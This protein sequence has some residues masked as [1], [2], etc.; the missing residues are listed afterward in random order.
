[1]NYCINIGFLIIGNSVL[2]L[3][4]GKDRKR[5]ASEHWKKTNSIQLKCNNRETILPIKIALKNDNITRKEV[6]NT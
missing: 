1:M 2:Y 4:N 6:V 3:K 5:E